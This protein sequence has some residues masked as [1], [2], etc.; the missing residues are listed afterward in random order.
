MRP[1]CEIS[2]GHAADLLSRSQHVLP[3][4]CDVLRAAALR[5]AAKL[6]LVHAFFTVPHGMQLERALE[7][8]LEDPGGERVQSAARPANAEDAKVLAELR[9]AVRGCDTLLLLSIDEGPGYSRL[10]SMLQEGDGGDRP[11]G[12]SDAPPSHRPDRGC[13]QVGNRA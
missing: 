9:H 11:G 10:L 2:F 4:L 8:V 13:R 3:R 7:V 12:T 5:P 1:L 6:A